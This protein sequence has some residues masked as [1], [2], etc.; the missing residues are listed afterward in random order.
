MEMCITLVTGIPI[1][2]GEA[3]GYAFQASSILEVVTRSAAVALV[4]GDVADW[5]FGVAVQAGASLVA[6]LAERAGGKTSGFA[7]SIDVEC[8]LAS[9]RQGN[10]V[11]CSIKK[12]QSI[13]R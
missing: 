11:N 8:L 2:A 13:G 7:G 9:T 4:G 12:G 6:V 1:G 3:S 10:R 5:A